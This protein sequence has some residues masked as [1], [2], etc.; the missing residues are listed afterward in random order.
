[1]HAQRGLTGVVHISKLWH[2]LR[3][4]VYTYR[5]PLNRKVQPTTRRAAAARISALDI[6][7]KAEA[8]AQHR[9]RQR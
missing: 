1:M 4:L 5:R 6:M 7:A 9:A 8:I 2:Q 3:I